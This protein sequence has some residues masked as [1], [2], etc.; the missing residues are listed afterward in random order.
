MSTPNKNN[1]KLNVD[2]S[3]LDSF[4]AALAPAAAA[5]AKTIFYKKLSLKTHALYGGKIAT[6]PKVPV[7][8][9]AWLNAWY[10]P[11]VS[12]VS[13]AIRDNNAQSFTLSNRA[14]LVAVVSDSTRVLGDG[15]C[16]PPGGLG[17]MEGKALLMKILGGVDAHALCIDSRDASG[18]PSAQKI[19]DFVLMCQPSYG[20]INL[21]D[22]SQ[23][24]CYKVLDELRKRAQIPVWHDDAQGTATITVAGL[25]NA[26]ELVGKKIEAAKIVFFGA[27]ASN[28]M[29]ASLVMQLGAQPANIIM[30]DHLGPLNKNRKDIEDDKGFYKQ[31][32]LC[33]TTN[34]ANIN[35]IEESFKNADVVIAFSKPGPDTIKSQ[36]ISSMAAKPIVFTCANPVPEIYPSEAHKA[37]AF[38]TATGRG[39]FANQLNNSVCFPGILKGTLLC[40][41]ATITDGM[42]LAAARAIAAFAKQRGITPDNIAPFMSEADIYPTVARAVAEQAAKEGIAKANITG[43]QVYQRAKADIEVTQKLFDH[44][45]QSGIIPQ[46]PQ[47]ILDQVLK[48]TLEEI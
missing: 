46:P 7:P 23:P 6:M 44:M 31:W 34:P 22:I 2:L 12:A 4:F 30:I 45:Q 29:T 19:I 38:I 17:V 15:D 36:W 9:P 1:T 14:N 37:G 5:K 43:E 3:N 26:L 8:G 21:E 28:T 13:T 40:E 35:T 47:E 39:D 25:I 24:N 27:G 42:A 41:A 11:G 33:Q 10:T 20:A 16:T 32:H 18:K 48:E